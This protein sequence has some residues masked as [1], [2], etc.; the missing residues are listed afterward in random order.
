MKS[1]VL[2]SKDY[3]NNYFHFTKESNLKSIKQKGL[4]PKIGHNARYIEK[5]LRRF[6]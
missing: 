6:L 5:L 2:S 3:K 4:L 1:Y